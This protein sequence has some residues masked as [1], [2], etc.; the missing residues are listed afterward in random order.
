MRSGIDHLLA[1]GVISEVIAR[2]KSGKEADVY[3][4][5]YGGRIVAAK[6]YKDRDQRSFKN[7]SAYKEGRQVRN[8]RSQRAIERGSRFGQAAAEDAWKSAEVDALYKL[9]AAE[10]RVPTPV[11]YLEGVLLMELVLDAEGGAAPRIID[12]D[13]T[14]DEA[15]AAYRDML[16][17]LVRILSCD[18]IHGDLSAYNVLWSV[19][20]PTI[21]DFPQAI[22]ASHNSRSEFFFLRDANNILGHFAAIDPRLS[23]RTGDAAEIW[24]AYMRRELSVDF[25]PSGRMRPPQ[26]P[27]AAPS[28]PRG[29]PRAPQQPAQAQ[30]PPPQHQQARPQ[31]AP[32][33]PPPQQAHGPAPRGGPP[34]SHDRARTPQQGGRRPVHTPEVFVRRSPQG[35]APPPPPRAPAPTHATG[36]S[37]NERREAPAHRRRRRHR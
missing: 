25:V 18:L 30:R 21:I 12:T 15:N 7:N 5:R 2:L 34:Q 26:R 14:A 16:T 13:L 35:A 24:R 8:S 20:G 31:H 17:Q 6:V 11:M 9:H 23:V 33:Q 27:H 37:E 1:E 19:R 3:V 32:R 28:A 22:S 4:V 29:Q 36:D 10:V